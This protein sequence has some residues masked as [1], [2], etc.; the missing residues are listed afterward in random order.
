MTYFGSKID[1]AFDDGDKIQYDPNDV[2]AVIYDVNPRPG[3]VQVKPFIVPILL[4]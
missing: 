2:N 1:V 4:T 3:N